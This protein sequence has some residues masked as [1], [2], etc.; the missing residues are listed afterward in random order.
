[1]KQT[2]SIKGKQITLESNAFTTL[3]YKKQFNKDFF[4]ELLLVA[5]VFNGRKSFSLEDLDTDSLE[6]FD[7]ELFYRLFWIFAVTADP[8]VPDYLDFYRVNS[9]LELKDI[10][11]NVGKL[12][13]VSLVT[14]KKPTQVK[15]RVKKHSR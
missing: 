6:A 12:L 4:K 9:Y 13:E 2:I 14:K 10:M 8:S 15:K 3:L 7:S 11:Q 1:M 5:K